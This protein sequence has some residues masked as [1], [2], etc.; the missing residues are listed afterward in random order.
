[1]SCIICVYLD[2][3]MTRVLTINIPMSS[4]GSFQL[5][6]FPSLADTFTIFF[7]LVILSR[8]CYYLYH[9]RMAGL[10]WVFSLSSD[11]F[12]EGNAL[13]LGF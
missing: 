2:S 12:Q 6:S 5:R 9:L 10:S 13:G 7:L 11:A 4:P 8:L 1:M 3:R